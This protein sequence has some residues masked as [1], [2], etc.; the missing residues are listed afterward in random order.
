MQAVKLSKT[1]R[2]L[3]TLMA[4]GSPYGSVVFVPGRE[5]ATNSQART[6]YSFQRYQPAQYGFKSYVRVTAPVERLIA[7]K[8]VTE[9]RSHTSRCEVTVTA[10]GR[11]WLAA[12][13]A[14]HPS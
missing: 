14:A 4:S 8:L 13:N 6:C 3:L 1:D 11:A 2:G 7:A 12:W 9:P 5:H 10:Q